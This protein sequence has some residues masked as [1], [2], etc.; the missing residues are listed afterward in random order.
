MKLLLKRTLLISNRHVLSDPCVAPAVKSV[1]SSLQLGMWITNKMA[2]KN[3]VFGIFLLGE[4][5]TV[6]RYER[7]TNQ[8]VEK[9]FTQAV[10][11]SFIGL[12]LYKQCCRSGHQADPTPLAFPMVVSTASTDG[13]STGTR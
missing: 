11:K 13:V 3:T 12:C 10:E 1:S 2:R 7:I 6:S 4:F 8:L 9:H 5:W